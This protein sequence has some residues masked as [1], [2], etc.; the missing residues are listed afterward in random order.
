MI[1]TRGNSP[2]RLKQFSRHTRTHSRKSVARDGDVRALDE[3]A[4]SL[5]IVRITAGGEA[6]VRRTRIF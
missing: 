5:N 4:L 6:E 2:S 1:V 3:G